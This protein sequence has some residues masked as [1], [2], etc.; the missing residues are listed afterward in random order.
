MEE[1]K[2]KIELFLSV[3]SG[4]GYGDGSGYGSGSGS[5]S[6][7]GD[8]SG[9]GYGD[10]SGYGYGDGSGYG[11][12]SGSG[13]GSGYGSGSGDGSGLKSFDKQ[14]VYYIDNIPTVIERVHGNLAKGF[15]V[16]KDLTTE[17]CYVAKG[18][19]M[20]AHGATAKEAADA[21]QAKIIAK[22]DPDEKIEEFLKSFSPGT[23][24]PAKAF[25]DWH[26]ILT[27]SCEFGRNAFVKNHGIDLE[28]GI[29]TVE[30]FIEL[31][32]N[33]FGGDIIKQLEERL[34]N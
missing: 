28:N 26:H 33:D 30:E 12:G 2:D 20:F 6:G 29:Y 23:K 7:Y 34:E 32:K 3:S 27:G 19:D 11:S 24:Y 10:G 8:G 5:G 1:V 15:I 17:K 16:N 9:S 13:D 4:S 25:Y 18:N 31:T 21:L 14:N 22:M